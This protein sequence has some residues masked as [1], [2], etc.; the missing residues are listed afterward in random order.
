M[1]GPGS[2][3]NM[4]KKFAG[5]SLYITS[6]EFKNIVTDSGVMLVFFGTILLYPILYPFTYSNEI[7][8]DIPVAVVDMSHSYYSRQLIRMLDTTDSVKVVEHLTGME[9]AQKEFY[10][11]TINSIMLIPEDFEKKILRGEQTSVSAYCDTSYFMIYRQVFKGISLAAGTLAAGIEIRRL[12]GKGIP[13]KA[14]MRSREPVSII[15]FPLY[16]PAGGY[17]MYVMPAVFLVLLQQTLVMGIGILG[18]TAREKKAYH[19]LIPQGFDKKNIFPILTGKGT[20]YF[21]IYCLHC[22]YMF[23]ILFRIFNYPQRGDT[24]TVIVVLSTYLS[25]VIAFAMA[26]ASILPHRETAIPIVLVMSIP[27]LLTGGFSWPV[28]AMPSVIRILSLIVPSTSGVDAFLKV[29][30]MNATLADVAIPLFRL[31]FLIILYSLCSLFIL[32]HTAENHGHSP[33][34]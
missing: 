25:A 15:S 11:G 19:Y 14:A 22:M 26:I 1:T 12:T 30:Q 23:I 2:F 5:E 3:I 20:S 33:V 24:F 28:E 8:R 32:R 17:A 34:I 4:L 27:S 16:N 6:L 29:T 10:S 21:L 18:G 9:E 13:E 31:F 7:V